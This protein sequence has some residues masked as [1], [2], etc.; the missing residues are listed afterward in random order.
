MGIKK[1]WN[2]TSAVLARSIF[3]LHGIASIY[4]LY[5]GNK[6]KL[7]HWLVVIPLIMLIIEGIVTI[8]VRK[9]NECRYFWPSGFLYICTILPLVW[10]I[11]LDLIEEK[12]DNNK[13]VTLIGNYTSAT[14]LDKLEEIHLS[15]TFIVRN[16]CETGVIVGIIIGRWLLPNTS[17]TSGQLSTMLLE[18]VGNGSDI[19]DLCNTT[20]VNGS[21]L[22]PSLKKIVMVVH[23]WAL[24]QFTLVTNVKAE[25]DHPDQYFQKA[26]AA[27]FK[28]AF[29]PTFPEDNLDS[30]R[31]IAN[32]TSVTTRYPTSRSYS[33]S[34]TKQIILAAHLKKHKEIIPI[35]VTL[36]MHDIPFVLIRLALSFK[37]SVYS[38]LHFF[39]FCKNLTVCVLLIYRLTLLMFTDC[40][41]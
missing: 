21:D 25:E 32:N 20:E 29:K 23:A 7:M 17:M 12:L 36:L 39:F 11:H 34:S 41:D 2:K 14:F 1:I 22:T 9:G 13:N 35:L 26:S 40:D 8:K 27:L 30:K 24:M 16:V 19:L 31:D 6:V 37:V 4:L 15:N 28:N 10:I 33:P 5:K 18:Y 38:D 3:F